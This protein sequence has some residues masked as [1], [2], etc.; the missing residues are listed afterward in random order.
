MYNCF[1]DKSLMFYLPLVISVMAL[2]FGCL[3]LVCVMPQPLYFFFFSFIPFFVFIL[4]IVFLSKVQNLGS[5][6]NSR[7]FLE[8]AS[9]F[10][11]VFF[12]Q[13]GLLYLSLLSFYPELMCLLIAMSLGSWGVYIRK[14]KYILDL[15]PL[16][17]QP[18]RFSNLLKDL[19]RLL[20]AFAVIGF[21]GLILFGCLMLISFACNAFLQYAIDQQMPTDTIEGWFAFFCAVG[22]CGIICLGFLGLKFGLARLDRAITKFLADKAKRPFF[23]GY[24]LTRLIYF[25]RRVPNSRTNLGVLFLAFLS[26]IRY[27]KPVFTVFAVMSFRYDHGFSFAVF[28]CL[29]LVLSFL[30]TTPAIHFYI[31]SH[32]GLKALRLLGWNG[33]E[34]LGLKLA[35]GAGVGYIGLH[36]VKTGVG[37]ASDTLDGVREMNRHNVQTKVYINQVHNVA[38]A[39]KAAGIHDHTP[40]PKIENPKKPGSLGGIFKK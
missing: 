34:I 28:C 15:Y 12:F 26:F 20:L 1:K 5:P 37:M 10:F 40:I 16:A 17:P 30:V 25:F 9:L 24:G 31:T 23:W 33:P 11:V 36:V 39:N 19:T 7:D 13:G 21:G 6:K 2:A 4:L 18:L 27:V 3:S 35:A 32:F 8:Y 38:A 22:L 29:C 14:Q